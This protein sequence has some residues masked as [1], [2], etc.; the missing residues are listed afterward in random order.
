MLAVAPFDVQQPIEA[1]LL[2]SRMSIQPVKPA[3]RRIEALSPAERLEEALSESRTMLVAKHFVYQD[4]QTYVRLYLLQADRA[5]FLHEPFTSSWQRRFAD[6]DLLLGEMADKIHAAGVPFLL[7]VVPEHAQADLLHFPD[8][9]PGINPYAFNKR[10][11]AIAAKHGIVFVDVFK[12]FAR[13]RDPSRLFYPADG[14]LTPEGHEIVSQGIVR[15]FMNLHVPAF[16]G[17]YV[18]GNE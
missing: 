9:P 3:P 18:S 6:L 15:D 8:L 11:A 10:I 5:G 1:E 16:S 7:T 14:H 13:V 2:S 4:E 12:D 17:C